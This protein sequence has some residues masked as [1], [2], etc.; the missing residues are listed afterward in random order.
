MLIESLLIVIIV[1]GVFIY[2]QM[3]PQ[4]G[5]LGL[6]VLGVVG[7]LFLYVYDTTK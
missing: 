3:V 5:V 2:G 6:G 4:L 7:L 1:I